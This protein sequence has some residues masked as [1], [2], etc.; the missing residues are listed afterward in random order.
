MEKR[1]EIIPLAVG[2]GPAARAKGESVSRATLG[3]SPLQVSF[4]RNYLKRN[5]FFSVLTIDI[6]SLV[7]VRS[8]HLMHIKGAHSFDPLV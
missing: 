8:S 4:T 5:A 3:H 2:P 6:H 7:C 1:L